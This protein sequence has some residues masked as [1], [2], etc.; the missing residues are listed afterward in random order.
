M[1]DI[2]RVYLAV[3]IEVDHVGALL[4]G[5]LSPVCLSIIYI[6]EPKLFFSEKTGIFLLNSLESHLVALSLEHVLWNGPREML[7]LP[8]KQRPIFGVY[9]VI[10]VLRIWE[11]VARHPISPPFARMIQQIQLEIVVGFRYA[12]APR[13]L[14]NPLSQ[15]RLLQSFGLLSVQAALAD[16]AVLA[17]VCQKSHPIE[18]PNTLVP[19]V[20]QREKRFAVG[21]E[22]GNA[23]DV[24]VG[25]IENGVLE[26]GV[27]DD[28]WA[29]LGG[30]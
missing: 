13:L 7:A 29:Q 30:L 4:F 10:K 23:R 14:S 1:C 8:I 25:V 3:E 28:G 22:I 20:L 9:C 16:T 11:L 24:K 5:H 12:L 18:S 19:E 6:I 2:L 15:V 27:V 17:R 21:D 26:Q